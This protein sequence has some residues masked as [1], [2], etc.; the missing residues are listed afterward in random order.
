MTGLLPRSLKSPRRVLSAS[1]RLLT[2][3]AK[4]LLVFG[5]AKQLSVAEFASY[6]VFSVSVGYCLYLLGLEYCG[7]SNR[8]L[9]TASNTKRGFLLKH[10]LA[11]YSVSY[12][13]LIMFAAAYATAGLSSWFLVL[14]FT[15]ITVLE[16]SGQEQYRIFI[17]I[18]KQITATCLLFLRQGIWVFCVLPAMMYGYLPS[19]LHVI[20]FSW[21]ICALMAVSLGG[22]L[23]LR[24]HWG[25]WTERIDWEFLGTGLRSS[26]ILLASILLSRAVFVLDRYMMGAYFGAE[27]L[28][29]YA[30][31]AGFGS[32][33][34]VII[35]AAVVSYAYPRLIRS[36]SLGDEVEFMSCIRA[37][38]ASILFISVTYSILAVLLAPTLLAW[39]GRESYKNGLME[40]PILL[41]SFA[42]F[43]LSSLLHYAIYAD[44]SDRINLIANTSFLLA[45]LAAFL[46]LM[47]CQFD[48]AIS[49][50]LL[51][52]SLV[53]LVS[54][55]LGTK[56][57]RWDL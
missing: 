17:A 53:I 12:I 55:Y 48:F 40:L 14:M 34:A 45:F 19:E 23:I 44:R 30:V 9:V 50:S 7:Y 5:L 11:V 42:A 57:I 15:S 26:S 31:F 41:V 3:T 46:V 4:T 56:K 47:E 38:A 39:I 1:I 32:S 21:M 6:S 16:H 13:V 33:L 24:E 25:G 8:K 20:L 10:Q 18:N 52:A 28:A 37:S 49:G 29:R 54:K 35:D 51:F 43:S 22:C 2:V 36:R 27:R